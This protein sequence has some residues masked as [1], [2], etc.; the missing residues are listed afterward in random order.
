MHIRVWEVPV[1]WQ[2]HFINLLASS[3]EHLLVALGTSTLSVV[4]FFFVVPLATFLGVFIYQ[5]CQPGRS[6]KEIFKT[7]VI[8]TLISVGFTSFA[9]LCLFCWSVAA[10]VYHDHQS[11]VGT[12]NTLSARVSQLEHP[13]E[14][15]DS[16]RKRTLR[17][18]DDLQ[19][20]VDE[21]PPPGEP[22]I[23]EAIARGMSKG[24]LIALQQ[25]EWTERMRRLY[26]ARSLRFRTLQILDE[27]KNKG[28]ENPGLIESA[29][30]WPLTDNPSDRYELTELRG[31]G[32]RVDAAGSVIKIDL[33]DAR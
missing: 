18:A 6:M 25:R 4:T 23:P 20:F 17:L 14:S 7:T 24:D 11:L 33:S 5:W 9:L 26:V 32:Y 15:P 1:V 27:Y 10:T 3:K 30:S 22:G 2:R 12:K 28:L 29:K 19:R 31:L 21:N 13:S 16:L 8:P